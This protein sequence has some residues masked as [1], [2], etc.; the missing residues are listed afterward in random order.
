M[1]VQTVKR[2]EREIKIKREND[3]NNDNSTLTQDA[4]LLRGTVFVARDP[5]RGL[6]ICIEDDCESLDSGRTC[7][8]YSN[9]P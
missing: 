7:Y 2:E 1:F 3:R 8:S 9:R 5:P 6:G 4:H